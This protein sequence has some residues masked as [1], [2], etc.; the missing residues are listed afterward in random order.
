MWSKTATA[1]PLFASEDLVRDL[2][3]R[4][5]LNTPRSTSLVLGVTSA[6]DREGKTTAALMT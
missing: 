5:Y 3:T 1:T 6:L 2:Y 4:T